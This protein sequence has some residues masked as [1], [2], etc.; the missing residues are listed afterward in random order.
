MN[1]NIS[2]VKYLLVCAIGFGLGGTLWGLVL[3]SEL[4]DL[5]FLEIK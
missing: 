4:P 1:Q 3:Y 2:L 5:E